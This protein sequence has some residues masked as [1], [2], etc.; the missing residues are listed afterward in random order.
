MNGTFFAGVGREPLGMVLVG[1]TVWWHNRSQ[2][3]IVSARGSTG[4]SV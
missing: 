2:T 4:G 1:K 3:L